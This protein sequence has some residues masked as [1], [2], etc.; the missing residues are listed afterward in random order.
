MTCARLRESVLDLARG[1]SLPEGVVASVRQHLAGCARCAAE[2]ER[3]RELTA[4]LTAL[5]NDARS[6]RAS[7]AIEARLQAAFAEREAAAAAPSIAIRRA[8][9]WVSIAA[10]AAIVALA[11]WTGRS[12]APPSGGVGPAVAA[13][14][15]PAGKSRAAA[16]A[17]AAV[18][19]A[20]PRVDTPRSIRTPGV[21]PARTTRHV[22]P[23]PVRSFE[24]LT[25]PGAAGL[26]DLESGTVVRMEV[27]VAALPGYG[28]EI[29]PDTVKTTVQA[30]LLV[31]Q[32]GQPRAIRLVGAEESS[33]DT[34]SRR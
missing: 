25:L 8:R 2:L 5:A 22:A 34:R 3:Q 28:V 21:S 9:R 16:G 26:P 14:P 31:G 13:P 4:G 30:D 20:L 32:D 10:A 24:F 1:E 27:P 15:P 6:W 17:S 19:S 18:G 29:A 7:P 33:Q 11:L 12:V 23:R